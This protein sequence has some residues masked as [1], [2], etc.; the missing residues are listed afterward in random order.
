MTP[1][2]ILLISDDLES[3]R[4]WHYAFQQTGMETTIARLAD[5]DDTQKRPEPLHDLIIIDLQNAQAN[6]R[7][8]IKRLREDNT[9]PILFLM[10]HHNEMQILETYE[11]GADEVIIAP[12]SFKL[13]VAKV[14]AWVRRSWTVPTTLLDSFQV[15]QLRLDTAHRQLIRE[16]GP[17][18]RL[19]GLEFRLIHLLMSHA[20]QV[21]ES[22]LIVDRVWGVNGG[23]DTTLLK[24]LI[25]RVRRKIEPDPTNP[26][27]I[28][29]VAGEGYM[30]IATG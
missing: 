30:L 14:N 9:I 17:P 25:Y 8:I 27:Y 28:Q 16:S 29:A 20:G 19:T 26:R 15:G 11:A 18:I 6:R 22:P 24:N 3:A 21:L 13:M 2:K 4:V 5:L 10:H 1:A 7:E 12:V 23:G